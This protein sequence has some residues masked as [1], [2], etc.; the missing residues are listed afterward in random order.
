M[1]NLKKEH[2]LTRQNENKVQHSQKH[3]ANLQKNSTLYFQV[4]LILCLLAVYGALEMRFES[5]NLAVIEESVE[6][7]FEEYTL[8]QKQYKIIKD[9]VKVED[10]VKRQPKHVLEPEIIENDE[11]DAEETTDLITDINEPKTEIDVT[12]VDLK[13][14]TVE[15][16]EDPIADVPFV[17]IE[18]V[19]VYPGCEGETTNHGRKKCFSEKLSELVRK[20]FDT[21]LGNQLGLRE[22]IQ[23]IYVNFRITKTGNVEVLRTRAPHQ[24]LEKEANRVVNTI[25]KVQ[26]GKQ[27]GQEVSVLYTLP[28]MFQ[29][30]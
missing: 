25:P 21:D 18:Q 11:P 7:V 22:G 26:P 27:G 17:K 20:K 19:P 13:D 16:P 4:G 3:D 28:I 8:D 6:P 2:N 5:T 14:I 10:P 23:K 30:R 1:K 29:V 12:K 24:V 9:A 15:V